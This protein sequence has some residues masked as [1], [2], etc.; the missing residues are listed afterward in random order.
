MYLNRLYYG[1]VCLLVPIL[2]FSQNKINK[3]SKVKW[4]QI[5]RAAED[6]DN[7][8]YSFGGNLISAVNSINLKINNQ[9][10]LVVRENYSLFEKTSTGE[11][12][13]LW[14]GRN[15]E[16]N[17]LVSIYVDSEDK[18]QIII[19][20]QGDGPTLQDTE[21]SDAIINLDPVLESR[22]KEKVQYVSNNN[23]SNQ[24]DVL[25]Q[26]TQD[27]FEKS[28]FSNENLYKNFLR[29]SYDQMNLALQN[30]GISFEHLNVQVTH[31]EKINHI[32]NINNDLK[33]VLQV[34]KNDT[35]SN[36]LMDT[37]K[38]DVVA[39]IVG[40]ELTTTCG[41]AYLPDEKNGNIIFT[42][43]HVVHQ[44][45][46]YRYDHLHELGHNM[47]ANHDLDNIQSNSG[48]L[49]DL[50]HGHK[51]EGV[52]RTIMSY[53]CKTSS[54][55]QRQYFSN[56]NISIDVLGEQYATGIDGVSDNAK[57][58]YDY[59]KNLASLNADSNVNQST[60]TRKGGS[61]GSIGLGLD[62]LIEKLFKPRK[63]SRKYIIL[64]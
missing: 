32:S 58:L 18:N 31:I 35:K 60:I 54:C 39:L 5:I 45:C 16:T 34:L 19:Q 51:V 25:I 14:H 28:N 41:I 40:G 42:P 27:A 57:V 24:I 6:T 26:Y 8:T 13:I 50:N 55:P 43:Y 48:F 23:G 33:S 46:M 2:G 22:I 62:Y 11:F 1:V 12:F 15:T 30:S 38:A 37:H 56:P 3:F 7:D 59:G 17:E 52:F 63:A 36:Q 10:T 9:N 20:N 49:T 4:D 64:P 21:T 29:L 61:G 47:G 53:S 44:D